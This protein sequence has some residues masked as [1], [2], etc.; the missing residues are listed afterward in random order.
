MIVFLKTRITSGRYGHASQ[1]VRKGL[2]LLEQ[3]EQEE[4]AKLAWL[5]GAVKKGLD[6]LDRGEGLQFRSANKLE[7][8]IDRLG[9]ETSADLASGNKRG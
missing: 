6:Q 7:R 2:R 8:H 3:R 1:V 9:E 4:Q 5:R